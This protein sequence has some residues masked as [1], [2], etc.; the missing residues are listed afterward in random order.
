MASLF[1]TISN[2]LDRVIPGM[3]N[4]QVASKMEEQSASLKSITKILVKNNDDLRKDVGELKKEFVLGATEFSRMR[5]YFERMDNAKPAEKV[6]EREGSSAPS[7]ILQKLI[8]SL[9]RRVSPNEPKE[10]ELKTLEE[11]RILKTLTFKTSQDIEFIKSNFEEKIKNKDR[12]LLAKAIASA[13]DVDADNKKGFLSSILG[14][15]TGAGALIV[16]NLGRVFISG[17]SGITGLL[18]GLPDALKLISKVF[19][20]IAGLLAGLATLLSGL[21]P[22]F[23]SIGAALMRIPF[24]IAK[25]LGAAMVGSTILLPG[26]GTQ[27][28]EETAPETNQ[29]LLPRPPRD[30][31]K[32]GFFERLWKDTE[33][34]IAKGKREDLEREIEARKKKLEANSTLQTDPGEI[35]NVTVFSGA[36]PEIKET[37]E[38][39]ID[40]IDGAL[41]S[42]K[43]KFDQLKESL[44]RESGLF[45]FDDMFKDIMNSPLGKFAIDKLKGLGELQFEDG[46]VNIFEG[47][48]SVLGKMYDKGMQEAEELKSVLEQTFKENPPVSLNSSTVVTGGTNQQLTIQ[49]ASPIPQSPS[50]ITYL[51]SKGSLR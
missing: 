31:E 27:A 47:I 50:I 16:G 40:A 20:P 29:S 39:T 30:R 17:L 51:Q 34:W 26:E 2:A 44:M 25:A 6:K 14:A 28:G 43:D 5:Q 13:M 12:D 10:I 22:L 23:A 42:V 7:G 35:P 1:P 8:S 37:A 49:D 9:T 32:E 19:S 18:K 4:K 48:P 38:D 46:K 11:I 15:I 41:G 24:P 3:D 33:D 36:E 21:K 45:E